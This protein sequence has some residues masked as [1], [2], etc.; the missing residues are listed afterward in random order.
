MK[1]H[2]E[3][4]AGELRQLGD[5]RPDLFDLGKEKNTFKAN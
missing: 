4:V 3:R 2:L 5:K 1:T